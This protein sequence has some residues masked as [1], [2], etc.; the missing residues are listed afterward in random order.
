[1]GT[2]VERATAM[3]DLSAK[4]DSYGIEHEKVDGMDLVAVLEV[5][6]RATQ[7]GA[8]DRRALRHRGA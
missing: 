4:F 3:T 5:A 7:A 2:S 6:E 1:M 8:R